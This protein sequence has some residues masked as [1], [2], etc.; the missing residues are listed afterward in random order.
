MVDAEGDG[1]RI[2]PIAAEERDVGAVQRGDDRGDVA[3]VAG[4]AGVAGV[5]AVDGIDGIDHR[6]AA[7]G[8]QDLPRQVRGRGVRN[9]I[10]RVHD[11]EVLVPRHLDDLVRQRQHVLRLAEQRVRGRLDAMKGE[12]GLVGA[13]PERRVAA[14]NVY[15]VAAGRERLPELGRDDAAASDRRIA[16][17][18][19]P[20]VLDTSLNNVSLVTGSRTTT[21]SAQVT[22]ACA[23]NWASRLSTSCLNSGLLRR[24][25]TAFGPGWNWLA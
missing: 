24:V 10:M 11:I 19:D 1:F 6:A 21:P 7:R 13:E 5:D 18:A 8:S 17:D 12:P 4:A 20:H 3:G 9:R 14:Q 23:P 25:P 15:V 16:D 2:G 22:P